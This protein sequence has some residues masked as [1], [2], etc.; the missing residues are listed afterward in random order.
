M[1]TL[2]K[3]IFIQIRYFSREI[4]KKIIFSLNKEKIKLNSNTNKVYIFL[5]AD[6]ANMGDV[7][8][9]YAQKMY[10]NNILPEY[11]L[12]EIPY[13]KTIR[14]IPFLKRTIKSQDI[15]TIVGGGNLT[16][17]YD[18]LEEARRMVIKTF[19]KNNIISFPQT[20][21]FTQDILGQ[22]SLRRTKKIYSKHKNL[23]LFA[24]ENKSYQ[25]MKENFTKI[26]LKCENFKVSRIRN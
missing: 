24:R 15:I 14:L 5:A 8:I 26:A 23:I 4:G 17:R 9:T 16:N 20:I 18:G 11:E 1:K 12:I 25:F 21:E 13:K 6:Y 7:A 2:F 22:E 10:I 19:K 3:R